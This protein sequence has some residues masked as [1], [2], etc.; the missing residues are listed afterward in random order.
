[1]KKIVLTALS[2]L[3][4]NSYG[5]FEQVWR[6]YLGSNTKEIRDLTINSV[7]EKFNFDIEFTTW[8]FEL[9]VIHNENSLRNLNAFNPD[10]TII[11][12][13]SAKLTKPTLNFGTFSLEHTHNDYDLSKWQ[14]VLNQTGSN[15]QYDIRTKFGY[16]YDFFNRNL[17]LQSKLVEAEYDEKLTQSKL[18]L[19]KEYLDVFT[20]FI[21]AKLN[22]Y[23]VRFNKKS[24]DR[25]K[26]RLQLIKERVK[27][28]S[29]RK[30]DLYL[31]KSSY[32]T[33][34]E[35]IENAKKS[36]EENLALLEFILGKKLDKSLLRFIKWEKIP[37]LSLMPTKKN[38]DLKLAEAR[39]H[40]SQ[41]SLNKIK[42]DSSSSLTL[43]LEYETNGVR[44]DRGDAFGDNFEDDK[45]Q[46]IS[47]IYKIPL[48]LDRRDALQRR[49][50]LEK[51]L[52]EKQLENKIGEIE[53]RIKTLQKQISLTQNAFK[54]AKQRS[55]SLDLALKETN[56][57]YSRGQSDFDEVIRR[58][59]SFISAKLSE[60]STLAN[61]ELLIAN[62]AFLQG[63]IKPYLDSYRD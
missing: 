21:Q 39:L 24:A 31:S 51:K 16:S 41:T 56:K 12:I 43:N 47:L 18:E 30:V 58:E 4:I 53:T 61:L 37:S 49:L 63:N 35:N 17:E 14:P 10:E 9:S 59:E 29:S 54:D 23:Q 44:D 50:V 6:A 38:L 22:L 27:T 13:Y 42:N 45:N 55:K 34:T 1:M 25:A 11:D 52:R 20:K 28:G 5:A 3:S 26:K 57:L 2:L 8:N 15:F 46:T 48:G 60:K 19:E 32:L 7:Q 40:L 62:L 36:L 33:Q